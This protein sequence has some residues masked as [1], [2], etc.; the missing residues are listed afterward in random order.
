MKNKIKN[1]IEDN[2]E[3]V[4]KNIGTML[5][6]NPE[7]SEKE[8]KSCK[9]IVDFMEMEGFSV[10]KNFC[11][12]ETAFKAVYK[13]K[14]S[15]EKIAFLCEYDALPNIGHGCGHNL[16]S[17]MSILASLGLKSVI[18]EIGG[19]IHVFG[20]PAE[21]TNGAKV[22]M[23]E[24]KVF[25]DMSI[26][27]MTHPNN[28][29]VS[30]GTSLA[31]CP[32]QFEFFGKTSHAAKEPE[33]GINALEAV[34]STYTNINSL[35]QYLPDDVRIHGIIDNGGMVANVI[36]DY[37][38]CKFYARAAKR[39]T[40]E[41]VIEKMKNC[42]KAASLSVGAKLEFNHYELS[43]D[44][45]ITNNTL[46]QIF[47]SNLLE[48]GEPFI[49]P[50]QESSGSIDMGNV[51]YQVPSIHPWINIGCGDA[52]VHSKEFAESTQTE[53]AKLAVMR[54]SLAM[55]YTSYDVLTN[56]DLL[57]NIKEEFKNSI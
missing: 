36:P 14:K 46:S 25:E 15:G 44:D 47:N 40:V 56:S 23:T 12:I 4:F 41:K 13:G 57:K 37:A 35:R 17:S 22:K 54:A 16:I 9:L 33:K 24:L 29:T 8:Y 45:M 11:E 5:Y 52:I 38:S 32:I 21:E 34:V 19:E 50:V 39:D 28:K 42:A 2:L 3:Y 1:T 27:M 43:Y 51:S 53:N 48:A 49:I 30:S 10:E 7:I 6:K 20:T 18:D 31:L 26:A 55:A